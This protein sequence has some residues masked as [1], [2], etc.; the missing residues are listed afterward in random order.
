MSALSAFNTQLIA[1]FEDMA[2]TYPEEKDI[3]TA[4]EALKALK[5]ANPKMIHTVFKETVYNE[6]KDHILARDEDYLVKRAHEILS[7]NTYDMAYAFWI[8]DKHWKGMTE[9]NKKHVWD[10]CIALVKL[11]ERV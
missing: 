8:F 11:S 5:K 7:S 1:F 6:F 9:V 10:Y 4:T 2:E 3:R